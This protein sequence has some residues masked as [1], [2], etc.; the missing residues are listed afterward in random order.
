M[1]EPSKETH[2]EKSEH[3][4]LRPL[5]IIAPG[6]W[7]LEVLSTAF[8]AQLLCSHI[9]RPLGVYLHFL[10]YRFF[11]RTDIRFFSR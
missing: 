1:G 11:S 9:L 7:R 8:C 5:F 2:F 4:G 3:R 10:A 6:S